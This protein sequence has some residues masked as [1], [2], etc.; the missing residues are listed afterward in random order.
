M[1]TDEEII[2]IMARAVYASCPY[3]EPT[4]TGRVDEYG[5]PIAI[6]VPIAWDELDAAD[7]LD[8]DAIRDLRE[9]CQRTARAQL[10]ALRAAGLTVVQDWSTDKEKAPRDGSKFLIFSPRGMGYELAEYC[11]HE[12]HH[13]EEV[14]DGLFQKMVDEPYIHW[15]SNF[16]KNGVCHWAPLLPPPLEIAHLGIEEDESDG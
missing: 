2:E 13:F 10:A 8:E 1:K 7:G 6:G 3:E 14:G 4:D 9:I 15:N 12:I 16:G 11:V 5:Y